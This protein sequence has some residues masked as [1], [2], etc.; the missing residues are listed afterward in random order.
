MTR[1]GARARDIRSR[2]ERKANRMSRRPVPRAGPLRV[3][4]QR[5][6]GSL[7]PYGIRQDVIELS[8]PIVCQ[9]SNSLVPDERDP[10]FSF[11]LFGREVVP[12]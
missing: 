11:E 8:C 12:A 6:P 9:G 5:A 4:E 3:E 7:L 10:Q 2:D 1:P